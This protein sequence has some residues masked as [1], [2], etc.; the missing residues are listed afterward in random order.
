MTGPGVRGGALLTVA[1][2][3]MLAFGAYGVCEFIGYPGETTGAARVVTVEGARRYPHYEVTF[4]TADGQAVTAQTSLRRGPYVEAG[5][6]LPIAYRADD[7]QDVRVR[8]QQLF[9]LGPLTGLVGLFLMLNGVA[10]IVRRIR[11]R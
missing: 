2:V 7:P 1:R 5:D 4:T 6:Q 8:H 10:A 3:V 11:R 9:T